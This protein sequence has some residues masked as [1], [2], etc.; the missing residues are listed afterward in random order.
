MAAPEFPAF[1]KDLIKFLKDLAKNNNRDWFQ[2][3]KER[4]QKSVQDPMLAFIEAAAPGLKK[5]SRHIKADARKQGGSLFRIYRDTR[6]SKDKR[7]YKEHVA[8]QFRHEAGKD[9]H[10]PGYYVHVSPTELML[11]FGIWRPDGPAL[12]KIRA[13]IDRKPGEWVKVRDDGKM[14]ALFTLGGE[15]LKRPPQGYPKDH[16]LAADLKR[17][18]FVGMHTGKAKDFLDPAFPKVMLEAF[19]AAKPFMRFLC[20][21]LELPF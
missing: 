17:K 9:V 8:I 16:P 10:A 3:N 2:K 6:F 4:Y 11:G 18:D 19:A 15:S 21:A 1:D 13:R 12:A 5:I 20:K 14:A 7:P